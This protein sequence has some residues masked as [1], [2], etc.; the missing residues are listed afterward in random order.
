MA[1]PV[2]ETAKEQRQ[3]GA[4]TY[5]TADGVK[6]RLMPVS[7]ALLDAVTSKIKNPDVPMVYNKDMERD[8]PNPMHPDYLSALNDAN[9]K[10]GTAMYDAMVMFG[11]HLLDGVPEDDGWI[12]RL[13][14]MERRGLIDLSEFDL[15]DPMDIEF[16]YKRYILSSSEMVA[17]ISQLSTLTQEAVTLAGQSFPGN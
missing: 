13:Q 15:Q 9:R 17:H 3:N 2:T 8:E 12:T 1:H 5:Q 7:A 14:Y 11:I 6:Y 16:V 4:N 10:R